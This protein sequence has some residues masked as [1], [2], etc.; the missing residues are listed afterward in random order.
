MF[1]TGEI[2]KVSG[3]MCST[4]G[5]S[6]IVGVVAIAIAVGANCASDEGATAASF[7]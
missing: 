1:I 7:Y 6:G 4:I 3:A 2:V 5:R